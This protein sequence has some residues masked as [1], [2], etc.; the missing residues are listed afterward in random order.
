MKAE[1]TGKND[2]GSIHLAFTGI[3][4]K[5]NYSFLPGKYIVIDL[6][7]ILAISFLSITWFRGNYLINSGDLGLIIDRIKYFYLTQYTWDDTVSIGYT[8]PVQHAGLFI[9]GLYGAITEIL[10]LSVEFFEKSFFYIWFASSGISMYYLTYVLGIKRLGRITASLFYMMNPISLAIMWNV[11]IGFF[12]PPYAYAPLILGMYIHGLEKQ[13][14]IKF[15]FSA[16]L[17]YTIIAAYSYLWPVVVGLHWAP[18]ALF[19]LYYLLINKEPE[20]RKFAIKYT[21]LFLGIWLLLNLY[22]IAPIGYTIADQF[23]SAT[24]RADLGYISDYETFKLNS[25]TLLGG[26]KLTG[27]WSIGGSYL[28]DPYYAWGDTYFTAPFIL[29]TFLIPIFAFSSLF[30][31]DRKTKQIAAFFAAL[32]LTVLFLGKGPSPP[33]EILNIAVYKNIPWVALV[34]RMSFIAFSF[35]LAVAYSVLVGLGILVFYEFIE[36]KTGKRI[37]VWTLAVIF[38]LLFGV[39][40]YPFW[41]GDVIQPRGKY[42]PGERMKVPEYYYQMKYWI[43]QQNGD[44][45]IFSLPTSKNYNVIYSWEDTGETKG[46]GGGDIIRWF[47]S[48]PVIFAN[49]GTLYTAAGKEIESQNYSGDIFKKIMGIL[50]VKYILLHED[51]NYYAVKDHPWWYKQDLESLKTFLSDQEGIKYIKTIGK[52]DFYSVDDRYFHDFIYATNDLTYLEGDIKPLGFV[53]IPNFSKYTFFSQDINPVEKSQDERIRE[54]SN[55]ALVSGIV[56]SEEPNIIQIPKSGA[57]D[58]RL[59]LNRRGTGPV[60]YGFDKEP[61]TQANNASKYL[62]N[63]EVIELNEHILSAGNH[64]FNVKNID[65]TSYLLLQGT[66][67]TKPPVEIHYNK[68]NPIKYNVHINASG[69]YVL[70]FGES[71]NSK[72]KLYD[73]DISWLASLFEKEIPNYHFPVNGYANAWY[74][75]KAGEYDITIFFW[76]QNI[77]YI[78]SI[79][80]ILIFIIGTGYLAWNIRRV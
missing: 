76:Y 68:V 66:E 42:M 21:S 36:N 77:Y 31:N 43:S 8:A 53:D 48:K 16:L 18:I 69:P 78:G 50:G 65:G 52:L 46:Y 59:V 39:L 38:I 79:I 23:S 11:A 37:A 47:S 67:K 40:A 56:K 14:G 7:I 17:F 61:M 32:A 60:F 30:G 74:I 73:G 9:Y 80:S 13:K 71:Y 29:I 75:D 22:W 12:P 3:K 54:I 6:C 10:G 58:V 1:N 20:K 72:W 63:Y 33:L 49:F 57:Y 45:R 15:I 5:I 19:F 26:L 24:H 27:L 64:T 55:N 70:V 44:F 2:H 51:F 28:G 35:I 34:F 25:V 62:E 41:T 4:D